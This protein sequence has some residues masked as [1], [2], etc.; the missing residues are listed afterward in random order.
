MEAAARAGPIGV[1]DCLEVLALVEGAEE[2]DEYMK[3]MLSL[4]KV[5][6]FAIAAEDM[7][8]AG[9]DGKTVPSS[10][11]V[12]VKSSKKVKAKDDVPGKKKTKGGSG[13][14]KRKTRHK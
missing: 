14:K 3:N 12:S 2:A 5:G 13:S 11:L 10:G 9:L 6:H 8:G 7:A 1:E 4:D